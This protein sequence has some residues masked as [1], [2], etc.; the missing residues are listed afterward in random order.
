MDIQN[1]KPWF[2]PKL[3]QISLIFKTPL[4]LQNKA[5]LWFGDV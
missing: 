5:V 2:D 3:F 1:T 4:S